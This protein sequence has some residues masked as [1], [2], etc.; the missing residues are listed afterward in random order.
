MDLCC[1]KYVSTKQN[2]VLYEE[3]AQLLGMY[4]YTKNKINIKPYIII[5]KNN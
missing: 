3:I 1:C 2:D 4:A 5:D